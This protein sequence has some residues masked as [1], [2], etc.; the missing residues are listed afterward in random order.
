MSHTGRVN[1]P[2]QAG[3]SRNGDVGLSEAME[4]ESC[5]H[6]SSVVKLK[7]A[8]RQARAVDSVMACRNASV[9]TGKGE[10]NRRAGSVQFR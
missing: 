3:P 6:A 10:G 1:V 8:T 5:C 4:S 7:P 2:I 9:S